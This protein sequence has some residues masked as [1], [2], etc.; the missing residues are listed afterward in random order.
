MPIHQLAVDTDVTRIKDQ[1]KRTFLSDALWDNDQWRIDVELRINLLV[2]FKSKLQSSSSLLPNLFDGDA[3]EE[4]ELIQKVNLDFSICYLE[5][6]ADNPRPDME[7]EGSM[8]PI[9]LRISQ[10][11]FKFLMELVRVIAATVTNRKRV[12]Q[13]FRF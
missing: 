2:L 8:S 11:Q 9:N 6:Q 13:K 3:V 5:H 4:L 7:I 12:D 10:K 1:T